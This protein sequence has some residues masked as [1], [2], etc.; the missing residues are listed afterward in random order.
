[1]TLFACLPQSL[2]LRISEMLLPQSHELL[3][4]GGWF[5]FVDTK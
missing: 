4:G 5:A 1:M 3:V 2:S